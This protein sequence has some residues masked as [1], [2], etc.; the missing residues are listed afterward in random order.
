MVKPSALSRA[1]HVVKLILNIELKGISVSIQA[2]T[3]EIQELATEL[4][5]IVHALSENPKH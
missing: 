5:K 3:R 4:K 2:L 1:D